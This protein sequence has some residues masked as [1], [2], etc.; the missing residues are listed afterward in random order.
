MDNACVEWKWVLLQQRANLT[1]LKMKDRLL[2]KQVE[3]W[4]REG[5]QVRESFT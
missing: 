2:E 3:G 5:L 4:G 1:V